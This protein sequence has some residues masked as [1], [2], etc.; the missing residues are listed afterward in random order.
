LRQK[1]FEIFTSRGDNDNANNN[2]AILVQILKLRL[3]KAKLLGF[4]TFADWSLSNTMAK[5]PENTMN[6][7]MSVWKPAVEKVHQDVEE[8]QKIVDK[9]GGNFKIEPWDYRYYA[10]KVRKEKYD[11][12]A[13][14]IKPYLQLEKLREGMFWVAGEVF[15]FLSNKYIMCLFFIQMLEFSKFQIKIQET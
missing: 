12:D 14:A 2:N 1:A 11:V 7:M 4:K 5:T 3:E 15:R 8:M 9:E 6:L 13:N 10:E